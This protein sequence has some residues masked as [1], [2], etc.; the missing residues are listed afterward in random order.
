[1]NWVLYTLFCI[2]LKSAVCIATPLSG[3]LWFQE[4][5]TKPWKQPGMDRHRCPSVDE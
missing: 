4:T 3:I 5:E 1:M 2:H